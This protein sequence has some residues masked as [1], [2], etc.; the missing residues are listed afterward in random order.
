MMQR[1]LTA[2]PENAAVGASGQAH[3]KK[4]AHARCCIS[5]C[6]RDLL[7]ATV[8]ATTDCSLCLHLRP[9]LQPPHAMQKAVHARCCRSSCL[10]QL[11]A[12]SAT[13]CKLQA[14][15]C[16]LQTANSRLRLRPHLQPPHALHAYLCYGA[17]C[18]ACSAQTA[19][20]AKGRVGERAKR[21]IQP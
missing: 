19:G 1:H 20:Q 17:G 18:V 8:I 9:H 15:D 4:A 14:T 2:T 21:A 7:T 5:S 10:R 12:A 13:E 11:Q 6:L 3:N 16:R